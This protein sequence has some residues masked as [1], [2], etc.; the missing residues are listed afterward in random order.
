MEGGLAGKIRFSVGR[1]GYSAWPISAMPVA[2]F[3]QE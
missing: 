3:S 2:E 1:K